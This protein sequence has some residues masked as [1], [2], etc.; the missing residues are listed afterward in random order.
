MS[1]GKIHLGK[2]IQSQG[3]KKKS[4]KGFRKKRPGTYKPSKEG[5]RRCELSK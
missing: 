4:H 3:L 2:V 5:R 1:N